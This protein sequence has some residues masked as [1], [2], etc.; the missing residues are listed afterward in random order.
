MFELKI[1]SRFSSAH[2]LR[3]Y[4]GKC[5]N[6]HGHNWK[7]EV[8]V[9]GIELNNINLLIDFKELK[10]I[11]KNIFEE[12][13][14]KLLNEV[15]FFITNNPS[16]ENIAFYIYKKLADALSFNNKIKVSKVCVW[17]TDDSNATYYE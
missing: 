1:K 17:E 7:V 5:E 15:E 11:L 4:N 9:Q 2:F 3:D 13:D 6:L 14:H 12:L 16:C 10:K 8:S